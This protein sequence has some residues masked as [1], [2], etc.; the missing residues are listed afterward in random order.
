[1]KY[2][3]KIKADINKMTAE[4][5]VREEVKANMAKAIIEYFEAL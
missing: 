5:M 2:I 4:E 3:D 1:M